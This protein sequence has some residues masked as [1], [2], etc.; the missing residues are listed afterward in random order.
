MS[1]LAFGFGRKK[2]NETGAKEKVITKKRRA[3]LKLNSIKNNCTCI[4][5]KKKKKTFKPGESTNMKVL[6]NP[7]DRKGTQQKAITIYSNDP[8]GSVQRITL[9]AYVED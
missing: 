2:K 8:Q 3:P 1:S 9:N 4:N 7:E 5:T 6:F